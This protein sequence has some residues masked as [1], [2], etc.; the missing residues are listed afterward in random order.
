MLCPIS[1]AVCEGQVPRP[2]ES[3][4]ECVCESLCVIRCDSDPLTLSMSK[5]KKKKPDLRKRIKNPSRIECRV[6][7]LLTIN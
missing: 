1:R 5:K 4:R 2:E 6:R 3:Y 7:S